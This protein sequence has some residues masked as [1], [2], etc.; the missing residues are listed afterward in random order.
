M[1][2]EEDKATFLTLFQGLKIK[3]DSTN[4]AIVQFPVVETTADNPFFT[5][6]QDWMHRGYLFP[7]F[8]IPATGEHEYAR[9]VRLSVFDTRTDPVFTLWSEWIG[10]EGQSLKQLPYVMKFRYN[11]M[12]LFVRFRSKINKNLGQK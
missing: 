1:V 3:K 8:V 4:D 2:A 5:F 6:G 11:K 9:R 10:C 12:R 7:A